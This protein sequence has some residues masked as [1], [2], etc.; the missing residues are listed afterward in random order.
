MINCTT[1]S[2]II[3]YESERGAIY[4]EFNS[5]VN[6]NRINF[7]EIQSNKRKRYIINTEC[8]LDNNEIYCLAYFN[9]KG[10][11][12]KIISVSYGDE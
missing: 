3:E 2:K 10:G 7:I 5:Q 6:L 8:H 4:I 9:V 1:K 12:Y 11:E